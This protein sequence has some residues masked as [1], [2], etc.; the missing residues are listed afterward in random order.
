MSAEDVE[1]S[2]RRSGIAVKPDAYLCDEIIPVDAK[3]AG[4]NGS[5][6]VGDVSW[7][8]PT[9]ELNVATLAPGVPLHSWQSTACTGSTIGRKGM[10]VAAKTLALSALDLLEDPKLIEAAKADF[11]RRRAGNKYRSPIPEGNGPPLHYRDK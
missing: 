7:S 8:I 1:S 6:D 5:T 9:S 3:G 11:D 2:F 10:M 4:M